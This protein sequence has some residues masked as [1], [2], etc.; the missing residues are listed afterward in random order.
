MPERRL[1]GKV[2]I[3]TGCARGQGRAA[4]LLFAAH[5]ARVA[6]ADWDEEAGQATI[7]E[8]VTA[9][10]EAVFTRVDVSAAEEVYGL[11]SDTMEHFGALHVLYNNA[12]ISFSGPLKVGTVLDIPEADWDGMLHVNLNSVY[13]ATRA[14]LPHLIAARGGSII[15][16]ASTNAVVGMVNNDS[17]TAAKGGVLSLTRSLAVRFGKHNV[18]V[19]AIIPGP[20]E[21]DMIKDLI[22][23]PG[24]REA[25][26]AMTAL[27]RIGRPEEVAYAALFLASD[28]SSFMTGSAI[29]VDGGQ[30][31][32]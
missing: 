26:E 9:G 13:Y 12:G 23:R 5:G 28:E 20:I 6:G 11:V 19:N 15:N 30:T 31:A 16:T 10:G 2:A 25:T 29:T 21:T 8:C 1:E 7:D 18:R 32:I 27:R 22:A 4:A 17:Y 24:A 14:A 3:I